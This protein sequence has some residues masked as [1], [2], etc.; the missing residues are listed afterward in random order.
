MSKRTKNAKKPGME[1]L[2]DSNELLDRYKV[3]KRF[4]E[5]NWGRIGLELQRVRKPENV[6][7]ILKLVPGIEWLQSFREHDPLGCLLKYENII[8]GHTKIKSWEIAL[9]RKQLKEADAAKYKVSSEYYPAQKRADEVVTALN[10]L[11]S[12]QGDSL[13]ASDVAERLRVTEL[14]ARANRLNVEFQEAHRRLQ[15]LK[16]KLLV[17]SAW[18]ARNEIVK[19]A[20]SRR[21]VATPITFAKAMAGLPEYGWI[22]SFR[23]CEQIK[24]EPGAHIEYAY[25]LF[26][27]LMGLSRKMKPLNLAK[28]EMR[29]RNKLLDQDANWL[30]REYVSPHWAYMKQAFA[31]C[32]G[33]RF[34]RSE[35]PYKIIG[36]F[37]ENLERPKTAAEIELA[38]LEQLS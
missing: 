13:A 25:Q 23:R 35:L 38:K 11:K 5:N 6:T 21:Y 17:E 19:F 4:F 30:L 1:V 32:R 20:K 7:P 15:D 27:L 8:G 22:H 2:L 9:T 18:Y 3:L 36:R 33:K 28:L 34:K 29:L 14:V 31:E 10:A 16:K 24:E 12:Q 26:Q 37:L